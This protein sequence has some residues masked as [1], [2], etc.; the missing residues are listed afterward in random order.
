MRIK[1]VRRDNEQIVIVNNT[2]ALNNTEKLFLRYTNSLV[3]IV[4][5]VND[6]RVAAH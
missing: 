3:Y 5:S 2:S 1:N 4:Y 6:L